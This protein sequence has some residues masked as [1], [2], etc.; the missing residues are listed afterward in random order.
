MSKTVLLARPHP[1]IVTEMKP[2]LADGGYTVA[3]LDQGRDMASQ[4]KQCAGAVI[5]L[6]VTSS[7][8]ASAEDI[9]AR[10][11]KEAP[12][13]SIV[14]ASLLPF[15]K[16]KSRLDHLI[17]AKDGLAVAIGVNPAQA[18]P[19][20]LG[21]TNSYL[22][23]GRDDLVLPDRRAFALRMIQRHLG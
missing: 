15:D 14:F 21:R 7:V 12:A 19:A 10:L 8:A 22:Y 1:F 13:T 9:W 18:M 3:G 16:V 5:S 11:R 2:F 6:A 17:G 4:A 20:E 23:I